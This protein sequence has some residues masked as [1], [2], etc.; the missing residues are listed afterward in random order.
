MTTTT[1]EYG[2]SG[3]KKKTDSRNKNIRLS[4]TTREPLMS[5]LS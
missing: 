3:I 2:Y 5:Y 4:F 1:N